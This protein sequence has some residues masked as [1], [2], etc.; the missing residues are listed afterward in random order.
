MTTSAL[1]DL[2]IVHSRSVPSH[3]ISYRARYALL[4][5]DQWESAVQQRRGWT[6]GRLGLV[7]LRREDYL[8]GTARPWRA[9]LD[10]L[11][12]ERSGRRPPGPVRVLTQLRTAGWLFNPLTTY[13]CM[14]PDGDELD[15]VVLEIT[16]TPWHQRHWY[17]LRGDQLL[18][19]PFPKTFH[20]S[21]F[22]PMDLDYQLR[23]SV[24]GE[25]LSLGLSAVDRDGRTTFAARLSG[26]RR[27]LDAP[28]RPGSGLQTVGVSAAIYGHAAVLRA[29]GALFHRHPTHSW[30]R[31][32]SRAVHA[33]RGPGRRAD[34]RTE[35]IGP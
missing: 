5:L 15:A 32:L 2:H 29:R 20:V 16:N 34:R 31:P 26:A 9:A 33:P 4:D 30:R 10:E 1:Y 23:I 11:V 13:F 17:V 28:R 8:D 19:V 3:R 7:R 25:R 12:L 35:E 18:G 22:L 24:P 14:T 6:T 27:P 21:P